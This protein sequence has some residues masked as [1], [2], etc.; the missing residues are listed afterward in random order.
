MEAANR[1]RG[2]CIP[3]EPMAS[4]LCVGED[5][6]LLSTRAELLRR[7]GAKVEWT[8][9]AQEAM[10]RLAEA[11]FDVLV[12]CHSISPEV[13]ATISTT[14]HG[15]G[16]S[17]LILLIQQYPQLDELPS[18]IPVDAVTDSRPASFTS[19]VKK[20]LDGRKRAPV[21]IARS[22]RTRELA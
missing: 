17:P 4:I 13:A 16:G 19:C 3:K 11:E 18:S 22:E 14:A 5:P 10:R 20:L 6:N 15:R 8:T 21:N 9:T 7:L 1:L 12:L 2:R